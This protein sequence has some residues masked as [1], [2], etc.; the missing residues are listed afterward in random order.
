MTLQKVELNEGEQSLD[1]FGEMFTHGSYV[2][3]TSKA[4]VRTA[5]VGLVVV[6]PECRGRGYFHELLEELKRHADVV[7]LGSPTDDTKRRSEAHGFIYHDQTS[8]HDYP[9][10]VWRSN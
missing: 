5:H 1:V 9:K 2:R 10:M 3:V 6:K 7:V 8:K 4:G